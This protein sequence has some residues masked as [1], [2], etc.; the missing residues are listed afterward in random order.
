MYIAVLWGVVM[1]ET[2]FI[3]ITHCEVH[4]LPGYLQVHYNKKLDMSAVQSFK[5]SPMQAFGVEV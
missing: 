3:V 2:I 1:F 5:S 4:S